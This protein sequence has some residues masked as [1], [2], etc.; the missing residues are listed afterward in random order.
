VNRS[1]KA[2]PHTPPRRCRWGIL[3]AAILITA[4]SCGL[5]RTAEALPA[6]AR[7][8]KVGCV[9]CH[10]T[11]TRRNQFGDAFRRAGYRWPT[12]PDADTK[13]RAIEPVDMRGT[14]LSQGLLPARLNLALVSTFSGSYTN[15]EGLSDRPNLSTPAFMLVFGG[16]LSEHISL[17]AT[18][19]GQGSPNELFVNFAR[20]IGDR[21]WLNLRVGLFEQYTTLFKANEA[22]LSGFNVGSTPLNGHAVS[23]GRI[24]LEVNGVVGGNT[25]WAVG[26]VQNGGPQTPYDGY[27]HLAQRLGG[28]S[29]VGE[30]PEFDLDRP[31]IWD[32][33]SLTLGHWGYVGRVDDGTGVITADVRRVG[34]DSQVRYRRLG[35]WTGAMAGFD[36]D[37]L[38]AATNRSLT[39]FSELSVFIKPWL[40]AMY[41]YQFQD[42]ASFAR[43]VQ[44]HDVGL[45]ALLLENVRLRLKG[46]YTADATENEAADLQLLVAF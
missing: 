24:G 19:A 29:M 5:S 33:L 25:F 20:L 44:Q 4:I 34:L 13:A 41:M 14:A 23:Q 38:V 6:F 45:I 16:T 1:A 40:T 28:V 37:R 46:T 17:F 10:I 27:Y 3:G 30:D 15:A 7:E 2:R 31:S 12:S 9:T 36:K 26:L 8:Y 22:L 18:W 21:P 32:D 39:W 11:I 43:V 42:A 35:L